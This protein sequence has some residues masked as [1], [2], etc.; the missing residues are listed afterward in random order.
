MGHPRYRITAGDILVDGT[1]ILNLLVDERARLGLFLAAQAPQEIPGVLNLDFLRAALDAKNGHK[2]DLLS[3]YTKVQ[4]ASLALRMPEDLIKR[5]VNEGFSGG[6]KKK[7][8][9]LQ[10]KVLNPDLI[11]LDEID[12]GLD[13]DALALIADE[14]AELAKNQ[15]KAILAVSHYRRL[16]D[17]LRPTHCAIIIDGR[18][19][20]TGGSELVTLVL[21]EHEHQTLSFLDLADHNTFTTIHITLAAHADVKI[22][23]AA[24]GDQQ[25]H[26]DYEIT[27]VHVGE[28]ADS[29]CLF[30]AAATN[31]AHLS[32]KVKTEIKSLAP[33][34]RS[35]QNVRGIMLSDRAKIL[36]E[37]SL[38]IDNNDVKAKHAL[39]VGQINP[40]HLFYLLSKGIEEHVAKKLVL[41]GFFNEVA[42]QINNELE[43]ETIIN[44][45]KL[46][47][48]H[49]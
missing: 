20:L 10:I 18:V 19:A 33:Q 23:I 13:V 15:T 3:F 6:E 32:I 37:P 5:F 27:M 47:L 11:M 43:R 21:Q 12:S 16:F 22:L 48:A 25:L 1:S 8:E 24:Y 29:A 49:A 42:S 9:V 7:N 2:T 46:R 34:T 40:E 36:G 35:I 28:N 38:V 14:L 30:S 45:I 26:K 17:V 39:A 31:Q 44:K 41:L 4:S